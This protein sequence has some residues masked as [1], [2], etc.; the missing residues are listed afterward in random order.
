M[1]NKV[2]FIGHSA[3]QIVSAGGKTIYVDPW[4]EAP[5]SQMSL[6]DVTAADLVLITHDHFDHVGPAIQMA[7]KTGGKVVAQPETACRL[8]MDDLPYDTEG[9]G[10]PILRKDAMPG[11]GTWPNVYNGMGIN[12]GGTAYAGDV[13]A[14]MTM[15]IHSS[16]TGTASGFVIKLE[17]GT[18]IY[19]AGDTTVFDGMSI[20]GDLYPIDLALLPVGGC[21]TMDSYQAVKALQ[22]LRPKKVVPMHYKTFPVLEQTADGFMEAAAREVPETEVVVLKPSDALEISRGA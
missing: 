4:L 18:T 11:F 12:V 22:L 15:A 2:R 16:A 5:G 8:Q 1:T 7:K 21:F 13:A 14:T 10:L 6:D 20:I 19:H 3:F 9:A 17:D